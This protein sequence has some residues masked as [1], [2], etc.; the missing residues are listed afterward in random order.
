MCSITLFAL[1]PQRARQMP[2]SRKKRKLSER[3]SLMLT[4]ELQ[5]LRRHFS[6]YGLLSSL[7]GP[8]KVPLPSTG[9]Q[10]TTLLVHWPRLCFPWVLPW[11][12]LILRLLQRS[13]LQLS[14]SSLFA[15]LWCPCLL[16]TLEERLVLAPPWLVVWFWLE[17]W[18]ADRPVTCVLIS[19]KEM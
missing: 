9:S 8:W 5:M 1:R 4:Y 3:K 18:M 7:P 16:F 13:Q 6:Q 14:C 2:A 10:P 12:L 11:L 19:R 17:P 15:M